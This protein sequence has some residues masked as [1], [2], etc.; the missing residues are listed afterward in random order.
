MEGARPVTVVRVMLLGAAL[1]A[2]LDGA[3]WEGV[4]FVALVVLLCVVWPV[5]RRRLY[6]PIAV[7]SDDPPPG[8]WPPRGG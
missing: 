7:V 8:E 2:F 4:A 5:S 1:M 3:V 6:R